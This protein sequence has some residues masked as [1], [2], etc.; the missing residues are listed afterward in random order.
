MG[1]RAPGARGPRYMIPRGKDSL[2]PPR[3]ASNGRYRTRTIDCSLAP[4]TSVSSIRAP[5]PASPLISTRFASVG[6]GVTSTTFL[7]RVKTR[8]IVCLVPIVWRIVSPTWIWISLGRLGPPPAPP[9]P[10]PAPPP[11]PGTPPPPPPPGAG[12]PPVAP[13]GPP[14]PNR[15]GPAGPLFGPGSPP[16]G[17]AG[18]PFGAGVV[19]N[20]PSP[21][22][23][24][25]EK[26]PKPLPDGVLPNPPPPGI[27]PEN[28]PMPLPIPGIPIP[29]PGPPPPDIIPPGRAARLKISS[30]SPGTSPT[31]SQPSEPWSLSSFLN[32]SDPLGF[33]TKWY[34]TRG[35]RNAIPPLMPPPPP[36]PAPFGC[37]A[38]PCP[39][40][41]PAA[42]PVPPGPSGPAAGS[43]LGPGA[44]V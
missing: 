2:T 11:T 32:A 21:G 13:P 25:P 8:S 36:P 18:E 20:P 31:Y 9:A 17:L 27:P 22:P 15:P 35:P 28:P 1:S 26:P 34:S 40:A 19:P 43:A 39:G 24:N 7:S 37:A 5:P 33:A 38:M 23:P 12:V 6:S 41:S 14:P 44:A 10:G 4:F 3:P 29:P 30:S 42:L 16:N